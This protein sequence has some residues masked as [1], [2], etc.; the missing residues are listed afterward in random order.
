[1]ISKT[2]KI[3]TGTG[4]YETTLKATP[5]QLIDVIGEIT[6]GKSGDGKVTM[7]WVRELENTDVFTIYDWKYN[8]EIGMDE[9]I[10]WNIG[11]H[12]KVVTELA[13]NEILTLLNK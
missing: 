8:R 9:E 1:M 4:F 2:T 7:E 10:V 3:T 13:K 5:N 11:G 12:N 6:F